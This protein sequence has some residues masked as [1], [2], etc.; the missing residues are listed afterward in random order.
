[1]TFCS[2]NCL[3]EN[4]GSHR[5]SLLPAEQLYFPAHSLVPRRN[6]LFLMPTQHDSS[7]PIPEA[8]DFLNTLFLL[9]ATLLM[10]SLRGIDHSFTQLF[11]THAISP[12]YVLEIQYKRS[13][14]LPFKT[15][16]KQGRPRG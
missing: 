5:K 9:L 15:K 13:Q 12:C 10:L 16:I 7:R 4:T 8:A 3:R 2:A 1:M 14:F 6:S 11:N